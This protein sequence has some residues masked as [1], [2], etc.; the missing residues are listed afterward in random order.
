MQQHIWALIILLG[1]GTCSYSVAQVR[2]NIGLNS[3]YNSTFVLD[4]GLEADPRFVSQSTYHFSPVGVAVGVE[5]N[6]RYALQIESILSNQ[7]QLYA[8]V[9]VAQQKIGER[10]IDLRY[11][12]L[13]LLL[14]RMTGR[15]S[16]SGFNF[17]IGP[18]LSL[19]QKGLETYQHAAGVMDI[20][21][22]VAPPPGASRNPDG[23]YT[24]PAVPETVLLSSSAQDM[25]E[26]FRDTDLQIAF[27]L[28]YDFR[29]APTLFLSA[30][31]RGNYGL[32]DMRN[33]ELLDKLQNNTTSLKDLFGHRANL[34]LGLQVG[35]NYQI[36]Q[37]R[38]LPKP[39]E[40]RLPGP[41]LK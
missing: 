41:F 13:P 32:L 21:E 37:G 38:K 31:L 27:G 26:Q 11:I 36:G 12:N 16:G 4:K 35:L 25:V 20:P 3:G 1:W 18:Q 22:G 10:K 5:L 28:G 14:K 7:G 30:N 23:S 17:M 6:R 8:I 34:L 39:Q 19:L 24:V 33:G 29:I 15:Q 2:A 9:D 40:M